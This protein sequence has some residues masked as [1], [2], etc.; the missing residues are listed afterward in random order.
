LNPTDHRLLNYDNC[1]FI[2]NVCIDNGYNDFDSPEARDAQILSY[3]NLEKP[4]DISK[5]TFFG[6]TTTVA[7]RNLQE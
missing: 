3:E 5:N 4:L 7:S 6:S 1:H 2:N